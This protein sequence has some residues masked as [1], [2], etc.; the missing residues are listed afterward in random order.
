M[1][2]ESRVFVGLGANLGDRRAQI[3]AAIDMLASH[4]RIAL[5]RRTEAIETA[6]WGVEDQPAFLNAV[7]EL[8]TTLDPREL[9][10]TLKRMERELGRTPG[11]RWGPREIDL[12]ILLFG[13]AV[14]DDS[15]LI[16][17]HPGLT[18]RPF[19]LEQLLSLDASL[20]HPRSGRLLSSFRERRDS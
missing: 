19:V 9:L 11:P 1:S 5:V 7:A 10:Q 4:P 15:S 16:I 18:E 6:P 3:E 17:P 8:Q 14:I 12:D 2:S 20:V 13:E